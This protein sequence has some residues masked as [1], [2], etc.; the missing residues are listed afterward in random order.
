[1]ARP[2]SIKSMCTKCN[3]PSSS[4]NMHLHNNIICI[5]QIQSKATPSCNGTNLISSRILM[6]ND[7]LQ[8][9]VKHSVLGLEFQIA[10]RQFSIDK[11]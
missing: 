7:W 10:N 1:M 5:Q 2:I 6:A 3:C 11:H 4:T 8:N 9:T